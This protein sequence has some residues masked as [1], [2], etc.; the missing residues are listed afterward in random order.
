MKVPLVFLPNVRLN[1]IQVSFLLCL[2]LFP[3]LVCFVYISFL[4]M[5]LLLSSFSLKHFIVLKDSVSLSPTSKRKFFCGFICTKKC[6]GDQGILA[7]VGENAVCQ[8]NLS[9][10]EKNPAILEKKWEIQF[11][12]ASPQC[13]LWYQVN[14]PTPKNWVFQ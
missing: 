3:F 6:L 10:S 4:S 11:P 7:A 12:T 5:Y 1:K 8:G 2:T 13:T 9:L 14:P